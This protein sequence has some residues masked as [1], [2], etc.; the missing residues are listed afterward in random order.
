MHLRYLMT[1]TLAV[2]SLAAC[3]AG[4]GAASRPDA[5]EKAADAPTAAVPAAPADP[6]REEVVDN[7]SCGINAPQPGGVFPR[8]AKFP[9]WGYAFDT[10]GGAIPDEVSV[11]LT[12]LNADKTAVFKAQRGSRPDVAVKLDRPDLA[13]SGFGAEVDVTGFEPGQYVVSVLQVVDGKWLVCNNPLPITL[14]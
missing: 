3:D 2:L 12:A 10:R 4:S 5:A 7:D 9:V 13:E 8:S 6:A 11:R 1:T 14:E